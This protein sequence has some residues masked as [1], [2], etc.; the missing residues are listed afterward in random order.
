MKKKI[1]IVGLGLMGGSLAAVC[2]KKFPKSRVVGITRRRSAIRGAIRKKWIHE[3]STDLKRGIADADLIV[4]CT[5][6]DTLPGLLEKVDRAA[7]PGAVVTDVGSFK[8]NIVRQIR[9]KNWKRIRF[10]SAHPMMGS[11]E[12]G[13][14]AARTNL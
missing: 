7:K 11:H 12:K 14:S 8:S 3:G 6:I 1:A 9:K 4:L 13:F 10:I 5:P 2:R